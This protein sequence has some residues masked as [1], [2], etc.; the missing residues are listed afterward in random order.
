MLRGF[1]KG[2]HFLVSCLPFTITPSL[3]WNPNRYTDFFFAYLHGVDHTLNMNIS[4]HLHLNFFFWFQCYND[5]LP[6]NAFRSC[7]PCKMTVHMVWK[8]D[9]VFNVCERT[10]VLNTEIHYIRLRG[11]LKIPTINDERDTTYHHL[12]TL[13]YTIENIIL[14]ISPLHAHI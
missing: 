3:Q 13:S 4:L 9:T 7:F 5:D 12:H 14:I 2:S 11:G 6:E 8:N 10:D 1:I